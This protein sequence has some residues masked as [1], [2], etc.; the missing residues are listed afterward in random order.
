MR[1]RPFVLYAIFQSF[2]LSEQ[3]YCLPIWLKLGVMIGPI[4]RKNWLTGHGY[5]FHITFPLPSPMR[6]RG[7]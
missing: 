6:N 7:F 5:R 2:C 3:D 1:S 4:N